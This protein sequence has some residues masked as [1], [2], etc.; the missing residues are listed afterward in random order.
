MDEKLFPDLMPNIN[1]LSPRL[2]FDNIHQNPGAAITIEGFFASNCAMPY[3]YNF[4]DQ[5][6]NIFY[7]NITCASD[8]LHELSYST[9][10]AA[11]LQPRPRRY[12][13]VAATTIAQIGA[14]HIKD[15]PLKANKIS[16][17]RANIIPIR[18]ILN[19]LH[20]RQF[21]RKYAAVFR[22]YRHYPQLN[23][24]CQY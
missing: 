8:I 20:L 24:I 11:S 22:L 12:C 19:R 7:K 17:A 10:Y 16:S 13:P 9:A 18:L 3:I 14:A 6:K 4:D 2:E 23:S 15:F 5:N 21:K 1:A